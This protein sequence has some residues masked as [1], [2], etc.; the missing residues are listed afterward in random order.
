MYPLTVCPKSQ[1]I[2]FR[3]IMIEA[4]VEYPS[5]ELL[6]QKGPDVSLTGSVKRVL[7]RI[8]PDKESLICRA[9]LSQDQ[10]DL[11]ILL[12]QIWLNGA[13]NTQSWAYLFAS[14]FSFDGFAHGS[15]RCTQLGKNNLA[16]SQSSRLLKRS[17]ISAQARQISTLQINV[18]SWEPLLK[19]LSI[20]NGLA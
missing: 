8:T 14:H 17:Y 4:L 5:Y 19:E 6:L 10:S 15:K 2:L 3:P 9:W 7:K 1:Q 12:H 18:H 20:Y 11:P 13:N 16:G